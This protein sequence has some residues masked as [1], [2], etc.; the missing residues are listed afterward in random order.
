MERYGKP[1]K[2]ILE[3][4][5]EFLDTNDSLVEEDQRNFALYKQQPKRTQC[6]LCETPLSEPI[7]C[8]HEIDYFLCSCCGHVNGGH[9]D[10]ESYCSQ[11][12]SGEEYAKGYRNTNTEA[13]GERI[14]E[15]YQ[16][17]ASFLFD[18]INEH[19]DVP[20][21]MVF[22]DI[23]AGS[24]YFVGALLNA[25]VSKVQGF[26][27]SKSQVEF[28]NTMLNGNY[29]KHN[30]L[31]DV[32]KIVYNVD[33]DVISMIGVLEHLQELRPIL[34]ALASNSKVK[35]FYTLLPLFSMSTFLEIVSPN[36]FHRQSHYAH[37]HLFTEPSIEWMC[38][39]YGFKS[40]SEWWF[41]SE[42][43]DLWRNVAVNLQQSGGPKVHDL[44]GKFCLPAVDEM[45]LALDKRKLGSEV[46]ILFE[47]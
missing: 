5:Q 23:G 22:A 18:S 19:G 26:E 34:S 21:E 27:V 31:E 14:K 2:A 43:M 13:Y 46:H 44:W 1:S 10:T 6:K 37:T 30:K 3:M 24:G 40:I 32:V 33:A 47:L 29:I 4:T 15:I 38:K 41:G 12:Y 39:E 16:P 42:M 45:Q 11:I 20:S 7:F 9:Q 8:K 17:K 36:V 25:N 35:Y 28:A